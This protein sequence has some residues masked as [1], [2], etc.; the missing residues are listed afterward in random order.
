MARHPR[1]VN[2][3]VQ[4]SDVVVLDPPRAGAGVAVANALLKRQPRQIA[5]V[6][7]DAA[8]LARDIKVLLAGGCQLRTLRTFDLFRTLST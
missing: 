7:C 8:T 4:P 6:S 5:Y 2:D 3:A 1:A